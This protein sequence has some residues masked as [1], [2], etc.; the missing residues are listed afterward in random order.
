M[1]VSVSNEKRAETNDAFYFYNDT[2]ITIH[3]I[4]STF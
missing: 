3:L 2:P 4:G 1:F